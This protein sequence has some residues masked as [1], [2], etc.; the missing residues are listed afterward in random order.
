MPIV[1]IKVGPIKTVEHGDRQQAFVMVHAS[2]ARSHA[3]YRFLQLLMTEQRR[4]VASARIGCGSTLIEAEGDLVAR[5]V[6]AIDAIIAD[7][8]ANDSVFFGHSMGG[9]ISLLSAIGSVDRNARKL[10]QYSL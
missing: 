3:F 1:E 10:K 6:A 9:L 2:G 8:T 5:N 4:F 7:A